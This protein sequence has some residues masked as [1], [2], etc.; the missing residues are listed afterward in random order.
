MFKLM[1]ALSLDCAHALL[2]CD[3]LRSFTRLNRI[4]T[5][6]KEAFSSLAI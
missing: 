6:T 5:G 3:I 1:L 2:G 4:S